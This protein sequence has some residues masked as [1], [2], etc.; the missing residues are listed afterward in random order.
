MAAAVGGVECH[1]VHHTVH[2]NS[3]SSGNG[4]DI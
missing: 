2:K 3:S 1:E 4:D